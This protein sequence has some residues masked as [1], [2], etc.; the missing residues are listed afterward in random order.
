MTLARTLI[1]TVALAALAACGRQEPPAAPAAAPE[2]ST[3]APA[4]ATTAPATPAATEVAAAPAANDTGKATY[5]KV[6]VMCHGAGIG[7]APKIGDKAAWGPRIAQ[8]Q[9][10][11]YKHAI[12]GFTG[13]QGMMPAK[14]GGASLSD[15]DVKAAV[16]HMVAA[17]K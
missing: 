10:T 3:P 15:D 14:G 12:E 2:A 4:A 8:G 7:G 1:A 5:G 17:G 13:S 9:D 16:D 6:C 11:L